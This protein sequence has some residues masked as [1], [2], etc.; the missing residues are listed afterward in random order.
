M[1]IASVTATFPPYRG[2]TGHVA[3]HNAKMLMERGH[4]VTVFTPR[5]AIGSGRPPEI[6]VEYLDPWLRIGNA[7]FVP[8]VG[9]RL[10]AFDLIHLHY[11]FIGAE[12]VLVASALRHIPLLV[13]YH[14]RL[15]ESHP[16]KRV[17]FNGYTKT[18]E[19]WIL[20]RA[21][22]IASVNHDHFHSLLPRHQDVEVPNGVDT[23]LF[24][25]GNRA[26][27]RHAIGIDP[28]ERVV[29]FVGALDQAHRFKNVP[30][31][32]EAVASLDDVTLVI[33]GGGDLLPSLMEHV[34]RWGLTGRVR[35]IGSLGPSDLPA[36]YRA[37]DVTVLPSN[38]TESFG[39]VLVESMACGT[40]VITTDL[41]GLHNIVKHQTTGLIVPPDHVSELKTALQWMLTHH[42]Q[43]LEMG[44]AARRHVESSYSWAVVSQQ[45]E[46]AC[47]RAVTAG[48]SP[49]NAAS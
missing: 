40:P 45:L 15:E 35:F 33:V 47:L 16:I 3:Y 9:R 7:A 18:W 26:E 37:A 4:Q 34:N 19:R 14:N 48:A 8:D 28:R 13:T 6:P 32:I 49:R 21:T 31:L 25:P 12:S 5:S 36:Y 46:E 44:Q 1:R 29:L 43:R 20:S 42:P 10:Q 24:C 17:L 2:G 30:Q 27:A 23:S 22:L 11:P 41:P 38:K 39:L